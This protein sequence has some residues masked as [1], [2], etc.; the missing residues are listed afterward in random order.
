MELLYYTTTLPWRSWQWDACG[1]LPHCLTAV[2]CRTLVVHRRSAPG[3][4]AVELCRYTAA[5]PL[6]N[7]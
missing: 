3:Q 5:L 4:W 2:S 1:T 6:G 7:G